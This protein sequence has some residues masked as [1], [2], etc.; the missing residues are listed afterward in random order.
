[1]KAPTMRSSHPP[2]ARIWATQSR[3]VFQSSMTSWSSKNIAV[4]TVDSSHRISGSVHESQ[5]SPTYSS[6]PTIS[7]SG[8][9][10]CRSARPAM[11]RRLRGVS[12][13]A[14]TW[15]PSSSSASGHS[16]CGRPAMRAAYASSASIPS[17]ADSFGSVTLG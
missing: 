3:E 7:S 15:S 12:S 11:R 4:G 16:S 14:Y 8:Q 17:C 10:G 9:S 13:S 1:M 5:Y 6:N 2:V